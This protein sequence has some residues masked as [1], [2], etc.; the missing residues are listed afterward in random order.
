MVCDPAELESAVANATG[1]R[2]HGIGAPEERVG[3]VI[4]CHN[5][6]LLPESHEGG[7]PTTPLF[8]D[9]QRGRAAA[10]F[11]HGASMT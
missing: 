7:K 9:E 6:P 3:L 4:T 2:G 10:E 11:D 5:Q 8:I 1:P